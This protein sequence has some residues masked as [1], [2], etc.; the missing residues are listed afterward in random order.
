VHRRKPEETVSVENRKPK[1]HV[2]YERI[3]QEQ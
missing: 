1:K 2:R 3:N